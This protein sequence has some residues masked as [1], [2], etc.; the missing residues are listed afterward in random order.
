MADEGPKAAFLAWLTPIAER[1]G[2]RKRTTLPAWTRQAIQDL[3]K[4]AFADNSKT[5]PF[6]DWAVAS[7]V[8]EGGLSPFVLERN[9][10]F[11]EFEEYDLPLLAALTPFGAWE[12]FWKGLKDYKRNKGLYAEPWEAFADCELPS[13][14]MHDGDE[15]KAFWRAA[16]QWMCEPAQ[17]FVSWEDLLPL[18]D[19]DFFVGDGED[20]PTAKKRSEGVT[21]GV[22]LL[23]SSVDHSTGR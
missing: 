9:T 11:L 21:G 10:E 15:L 20:V 13:N 17:G 14:R 7:L 2:N 18:T 12:E 23:P 22:D 3:V 16:A 5:N 19:V 1:N 4:D 6:V 8:F